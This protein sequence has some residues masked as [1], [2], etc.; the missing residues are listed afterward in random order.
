MSQP[1]KV[2]EDLHA[3][4]HHL[5]T[6]YCFTLDFNLEMTDMS[7]FEGVCEFVTGCDASRNKV[8]A[9]YTSKM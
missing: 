6:P 1:V 7:L 3:K 2:L 9:Q 8:C 4:Y 5:A